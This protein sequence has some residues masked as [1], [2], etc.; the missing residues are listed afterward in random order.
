MMF[1][2]GKHFRSSELVLINEIDDMRKEQ[3][4][5]TMENKLPK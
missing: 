4:V 3:K 5:F 1:Y 2:F